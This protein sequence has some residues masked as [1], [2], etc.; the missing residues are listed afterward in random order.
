MNEKNI[1]T[2]YYAVNAPMDSEENANQ[3]LVDCFK[4]RR[5]KGRKS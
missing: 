1:S 3:E 2:E 4:N 5:A